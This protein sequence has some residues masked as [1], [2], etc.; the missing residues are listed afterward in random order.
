MKKILIICVFVTGLILTLENRYYIQPDES[1]LIWTGSKING[2]H[3]G[4]IKFKS[5]FV[6]VIN[7]QIVGGEFIIDMSSIQVI[8][9]SPKYNKKLENHL[10]NTDF[11]KVD[12]FPTA[13]FKITGSHKFFIIDDVGV[14]GELTIKNIALKKIIPA[15]I[16]I[17]DSTAIASGIINIDRT[18]FGITYGSGSFFENLQDRAIDDIFTL[19]FNVTAKK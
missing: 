11:F 8:D 15:S 5:G 19:K 10:K 12:D 16:S 14:E 18:L 17:K 13:S 6:D 2:E 1:E 3:Y 4:N 7:S 9:M